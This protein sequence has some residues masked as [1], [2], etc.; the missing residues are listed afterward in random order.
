MKNIL[1]SRGRR[2]ADERDGK[3]WKEERAHSFQEAGVWFFQLS[4]FSNVAADLCKQVAV[5]SSS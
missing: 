2:Y 1:Q 3:K 5:S 4:C